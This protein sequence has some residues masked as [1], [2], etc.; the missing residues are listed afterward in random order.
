MELVGGILYFIF[1][2]IVGR[3]AS[4]RGRSGIG[5]F[6]I[7]LL[8]S[9]LIG[10]IIILALGENKNIRRKR[11]YE[12]AAIRESVASKY[13]ERNSNIVFR[14][15]SNNLLADNETKKCPYCAELIKR[16]AIVCRFCNRELEPLETIESGD[17]E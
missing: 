1:C 5:Y 4:N 8:L 9:P 7:S 15:V 10:F 17:Q 16:E 6:L 14:N 11:I 3:A 2:I 13:R 12:D